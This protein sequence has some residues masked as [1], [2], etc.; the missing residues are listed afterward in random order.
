M[1]QKK[2]NP[3]FPQLT[4]CIQIFLKY[5]NLELGTLCPQTKRYNV[6]YIIYVKYLDLMFANLP[7]PLTFECRRVA[8]LPKEV[9]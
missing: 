1:M 2:S 5:K 6:F 4:L 9:C 3:V 8:I 7:K